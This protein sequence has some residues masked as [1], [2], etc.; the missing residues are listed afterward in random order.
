M[1]G[2]T[3]KRQ[4]RTLRFATLSAKIELEAKFSDNEDNESDCDDEVDF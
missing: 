3:D 1:L 2:A 4:K